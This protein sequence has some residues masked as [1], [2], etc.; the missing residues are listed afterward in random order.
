[1]L[2]SFVLMARIS[3]FTVSPEYEDAFFRSAKW[4]NAY[5]N[6]CFIK[7]PA[8]ASRVRRRV[9]AGRSLLPSVAVLWSSLSSSDRAA[10]QT[11]ASYSAQTGYDLFVQDTSYRL[12]HGFPGLASPSFRHQYKVGTVILPP[13]LPFADSFETHYREYYRPQKIVGTEDRYEPVLVAEDFSMPIL[14]SVQVK[15]DLVVTA[16]G[17]YVYA[18]VVGRW[19]DGGESGSVVSYSSLPLVSGW[20]S[21]VGYL[22]YTEHPL[23]SYSYGF[24]LSD[25]SGTFL[26]D[27]LHIEHSARDWSF[28]SRCDSVLDERRDYGVPIAKSMLGGH[29]QGENV[30]VSAYPSD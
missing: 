29:F 14:F 24:I 16:P 20:S 19:E 8:R 13:S 10:W 23:V 18:V 28:D 15:S 12:A 27:N 5:V 30:F 1:M 2:L 6:S 26:F 21:V 4:G 7:K 22:N 17:G 25:V 9:I 3:G 11:C